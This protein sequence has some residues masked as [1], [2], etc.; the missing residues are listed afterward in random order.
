MFKNRFFISIISLT[1][2]LIGVVYSYIFYQR[3]LALY[4]GMINR[5]L[6]FCT[7]QLADKI[8]DFESRQHNLF[9]YPYSNSSDESFSAQEYTFL[10]DFSVLV[11]RLHVVDTLGNNLSF[12]YKFGNIIVSKGTLFNEVPLPKS[13]SIISFNQ[14]NYLVFPLLNNERKPYYHFFEINISSYVLNYLDKY[15]FSL[16]TS[17]WLI[18]DKGRFVYSNAKQRDDLVEYFDLNDKIKQS[19]NNKSALKHKLKVGDKKYT[20]IS[21][22]S[23]FSFYDNNFT[24]ALSISRKSFVYLLLRNILFFSVL[25]VIV[26]SILIV[27]SFFF[28]ERQGHAKSMF[29][30]TKLNFYK[31]LQEISI[32]VLINKQNGFLEYA[33]QSAKDYFSLGDEIN[34]SYF[35]KI[36]PLNNGKFSYFSP[37]GDKKIFFKNDIK[38]DLFE[39]E[40]LLSV[41]IDYTETEKIR[42]KESNEAQTKSDF[43]A[44]ISHEIRTPLN[45]VIGLTNNILTTEL[46]EEQLE[47]LLLIKKSADLLL[48]ILNDVLDVSKIEANKM[49]LEEVSFDLFEVIETTLKLF[50]IR[51]EEI[52]IS[53]KL[54][55]SPDLPNR[56]IGD[57]Y[58]LKQIINNIIGNSIKFT[59]K[60]EIDL[61]VDLIGIEKGYAYLRFLFEDSGIGIARDQIDTILKSYVQGNNA[62]A[63]LYGGSGLGLSITKHLV[64]MM[65]GNI[66]I[67]S[68]SSIGEKYGTQGTSVSFV[69]KLFVDNSIAYREDKMPYSV[70]NIIVNDISNNSVFTDHYKKL[71]SE[72]N[73]SKYV[74]SSVDHLIDELNNDLEKNNCQVILVEHSQQKNGIEIASKIKDNTIT[75]NVIRILISRELMPVSLIEAR[76]KGIDFV[77]CEPFDF[78]DLL[79]DLSLTLGTKVERIEDPKKK[80]N[81]PKA[82]KI[83]LA[84]DNIINQKV[85]L[86]LFK[87]LGYTNV[88]VVVNGAEAVEKALQNNY[89]FIF[90]DIVM[91]V[92]DGN[93]ATKELR[94][95]GVMTPIVAM[96]ANVDSKDIAESLNIGVNAYITKPVTKERIK[97]FISDWV[98]NDDE[99]I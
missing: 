92:M 70:N 45:G 3:Q 16:E 40:I 7:T 26:F 10:S 88:D 98:S 97:Q 9:T 11:T 18:D 71:F 39:T 15:N 44:R 28:I 80:N 23:E 72:V 89:D 50:I 33:N 86:G 99:I 68:P 83:L 55:V 13:I 53:L 63:R 81:L 21:V 93:Q 65:G 35:L 43:L 14:V 12:T 77:Y 58:R 62:I 73:I 48:N 34:T 85:A 41:I 78:L 25:S 60:G 91:P 96:T 64:E 59:S 75:D 6:E 74:V 69:L 76:K 87:N 17:S 2:L 24:L 57:H 94:K 66:M 32:P 8:I 27:F 4:S 46:N 56:I 22:F 30:K 84:E 1:I 51:T 95:K 47:D 42:E 54:N 38:L 61:N 37:K 79:S 36:T 5:E 90:M 67:S 52:G 19:I 31:L 82:L 20:L 29:Q 49:K